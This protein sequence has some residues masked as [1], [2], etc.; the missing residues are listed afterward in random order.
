MVALL[1]CLAACAGVPAAT[2]PDDEA[3]AAPAADK[4]SGVEE[5]YVEL[6]GLSGAAREERLLALAG[7]EEGARELYCILNGDEAQAIPAAFEAGTGIAV[8]LYRAPSQETTTRILEESE[9]DA[10]Q[11]DV[12][13]LN[14]PDGVILDREGLLALLR[15]DVDG[16]PDDRNEGTFA[17]FFISVFAPWW[18]TTLVPD[19]EVPQSWEDV[20]GYD[21]RQALE[22]KA[23][24]WFATLVEDYFVAQ[25]GMTESEAV[26]IFRSAADGAVLVDG[27]SVA[28]QLLSAG[29][30]DMTVGYAWVAAANAKEGAPVAWE[31]PVEPLPSRPNVAG[32]LKTAAHP[33]TALAYVEFMLDEGQQILADYGR[34]AANPR[35]TTGGRALA[36]QSR[37][38][39]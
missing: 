26:G 39:D 33:A 36:H 5:V 30:F 31:P 32:I 3:G 1:S 8:D 23:F 11:A 22:V 12:M 25:Q 19:S 28:G 6:E 15:I 29:E 4:P 35:Y 9:A 20:L 7:E 37:E 2:E 38:D 14:G 16:Y 13:C 34:T 21:G 18:N 17:W 10:S 27:H 24:D